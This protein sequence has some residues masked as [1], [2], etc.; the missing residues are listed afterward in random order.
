MILNVGNRKLN[1]W[2]KY[3]VSLRF[4]SI[5]SVFSFSYYYD[6]ESRTNTDIS[7]VL[8]YKKCSLIEGNKT[9]NMFIIL[10]PIIL[11]I[12]IAPFFFN[13]AMSSVINSGSEV[14][15]ARTVKPMTVCAIPK[16]EKNSN[17]SGNFCKTFP[18]LRY[19]L[20]ILRLVVSTISIHFVAFFLY[21]VGN[22]SAQIP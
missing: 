1:F 3:T 17:D 16:L 8:D 13:A 11:P 21:T 10:L 5:A 9:N 14:P 12:P 4:D 2:S 18:Y 7:A 6:D 19:F 15:R 22:P 20:H